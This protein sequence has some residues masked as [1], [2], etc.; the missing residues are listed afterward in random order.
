MTTIL[1]VLCFVA[2]VFIGAGVARLVRRVM[3]AQLEDWPDLSFILW[4]LFVAFGV[5]VGFVGLLMWI[6]RGSN[7]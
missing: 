6:S 4:P 1:I 3:D 7:R 2:Y 5:I